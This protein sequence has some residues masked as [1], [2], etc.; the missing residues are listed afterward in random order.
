MKNAPRPGATPDAALTRMFQRRNSVATRK[1]TRSKK[2]RKSRST[3][4]PPR[5]LAEAL[6]AGWK[7]GEQLSTW[8]FRPANK[9]EGFLRLSRGKTSKTLMVQYTA[10][11]SLSAPYF[12]EDV[13]P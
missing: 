7:I 4:R 10:L 13:E 12:L 1:V 5:S 8:D 3:I 2:Q 9:R 6:A 11:Y